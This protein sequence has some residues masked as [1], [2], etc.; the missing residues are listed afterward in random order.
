MRL[1]L[2]YIFI[3]HSNTFWEVRPPTKAGMQK[4][5]EYIQMCKRAKRSLR[6]D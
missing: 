4:L 1:K 3:K 5:L 2:T 6:C